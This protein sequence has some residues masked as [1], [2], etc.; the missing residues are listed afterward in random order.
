MTKQEQN[1]N[2]RRFLTFI[3]LAGLS[4]LAWGHCFNLPRPEGTTNAQHIFTLFPLVL[5][6]ATLSGLSA[7][8]GCAFVKKGIPNLRG[9]NEN[10][11]ISG[12][13]IHLLGT[14]ALLGIQGTIIGSFYGPTFFVLEGFVLAVVGVALWPVVELKLNPTTAPTI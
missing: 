1:A 6:A 5:I 4:G 14:L 12:T 11:V 9:I 10:G 8:A 7:V 2:R 13:L 3:I